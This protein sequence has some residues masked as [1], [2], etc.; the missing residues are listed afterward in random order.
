MCL[1]FKSFENTKGK[2][3]NDRKEQFSFSQ[4]VYYPFGELPAVF[5]KINCRLQTH[6]VWKNL[7][8]VAL[9]RVDTIPQIYLSVL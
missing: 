3:E 1:K 9:E 8:F 4:S 6:S 2:G 5:I 7:K